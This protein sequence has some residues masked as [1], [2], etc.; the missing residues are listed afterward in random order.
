MSLLKKKIT[1]EIKSPKK[2]I[3]VPYQLE[4]YSILISGNECIIAQFENR[5]PWDFV[6]SNGKFLELGDRIVI[7][8]EEVEMNQ[9]D[10][11]IQSKIKDQKARDEH[12]RILEEGTEIEKLIESSL[13][14]IGGTA[15]LQK[16]FNQ[17][18]MSELELK[19]S[20]GVEWDESG[21]YIK[22]KFTKEQYVKNQIIDFE[23]T[24]TSK[25]KI[26]QLIELMKK[27]NLI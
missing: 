24:K 19:E 26:A 7:S 15:T 3:T 13:T 4:E 22:T 12:N 2:G 18:M 9:F 25:T 8:E 5:I 17:L 20:Y 21:E 16:V 23:I 14:Y 10:N 6:K 1:Q 11:V 27:E